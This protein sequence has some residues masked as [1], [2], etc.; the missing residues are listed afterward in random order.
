MTTPPGPLQAASE[1]NFGKDAWATGATMREV[2]MPV[3]LLGPDVWVRIRELTAGEVSAISEEVTS[4][5]GQR[6]RI[7]QTRRAALVFAKGCVEPS[8]TVDE[9]NV[10]MHRNGAA[11]TLVVAAI[12]DLSGSGDDALEKAKA[13]FRTRPRR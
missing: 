13:R 2:D 5:K 11:F 10:M 3:D 4:M 1:P 6:I 7:D 8:F 9:A 12:D